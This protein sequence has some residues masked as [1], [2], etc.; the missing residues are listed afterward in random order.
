VTRRGARR[1]RPC[2]GAGFR[3]PAS[4]W[5]NRPGSV[6]KVPEPVKV[7]P[8][9]TVR[10]P[11]PSPTVPVPKSAPMVSLLP[12]SIS[13]PWNAVEPVIVLPLLFTVTVEV[14]EI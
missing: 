5:P 7:I 4:D 11:E 12:L 14:S 13:K 2:D 6:A 9:P 3:F 10:L 8:A 1:R